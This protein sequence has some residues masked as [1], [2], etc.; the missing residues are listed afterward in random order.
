MRLDFALTAVRRSV[1]VYGFPV[2]VALVLV[3]AMV[4]NAILLAIAQS[5]SVAPGFQPLA[6]PPVLFLTAVGAAGAAVVY[7]GLTRR[8]E[9]PERTFTRI[10]VAVLALSFIPDFALLVEDPNATPAGVVVLMAMHVV[11]A[12]ACVALFPAQRVVVEP[13]AEAAAE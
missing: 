10:V 7:W 2:R 8:V 12:V 9:D 6:Y 13:E 5:L 3:L 11:V 4:G 1:A